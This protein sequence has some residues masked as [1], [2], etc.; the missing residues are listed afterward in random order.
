MDVESW[1]TQGHQQFAKSDF[2]GAI[3]SYDQAL[4]FNRDNYEAWTYRGLALTILGYLEEAIASSDTALQIKPDYYQAWNNRGILL[5]N[6]GHYEEAI[7]SFD[8]ALKVNS[9][10]HTAWNNRGRVLASLGQHEEALN[11]F[12]QALEIKP[13]NYAAWYNKGRVLTVLGCYEEALNSFNQALEIK[14]DYY[15]AWVN[16]GNALSSLGYHEEAITNY[17]QALKYK[18]NYHEAWH[19]RG[20]AL[21]DLSR[22]E[23]A[24]ANYDEGLQQVHKNTRPE[25]W[26]VLHHGLGRIHYRRGR[27]DTQGKVY[28]EKALASYHTACETLKDFPESYLALIQDLI[29]AYLWLGDLGQANEW[30]DK[31]L[32]VF[33]DLINAQSTNRQRRHLEA[34]FSGISRIQVDVLVQNGQ[35]ATALETAERYKNRCLTHIFEQWQENILSPTYEQIRTLLSPTTALI[36]WHLSD[37]ALTTFLLTPNAQTP[38][39]LDANRLSQCSRA[40]SLKTWLTAWNTDYSDYR[41]GFK[42]RKTPDLKHPWRTKLAVRLAELQ[43]ILGLNDLTSSL[44]ES[45]I[46]HLIL[47]PHR[48]LHCLPL[49]ACLPQFICTTLPSAQAGITLQQRSTRNITETDRLLSI[50]DPKVNSEIDLEPLWYAQLDSALLCALFS[51]HTHL[52]PVTATH[53]KVTNALGDGTHTLFHFSG[54]GGYD[55]QSPKDSALQLV[56]CPL[57]AQDLCELPLVSY[58]LLSL[59]A[60]ETALTGRQTLNEEYV[61]LASAVL[62]AG[63][64]TILSTL[65]N[66]TDVSTAYLVV[67]FYQL[68]LEGKPPAQALN[69]AQSWLRS[70]TYAGL[71]SWLQDLQGLLSPSSGAAEYVDRHCIAD[72]ERKIEVTEPPYQ[73]E[74]YWAAFTLTGHSGL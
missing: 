34:Q 12:N 41:A 29:K 11:S 28:I 71:H 33:R 44:L 58:K 56:D 20:L 38:D 4:E 69:L 62:Q 17:D 46:T 60:C 22:Y 68:C 2:I 57:T 15:E 10:D 14:P 43:G 30:R 35:L 36:Y 25:G 70:V 67:K 13:D 66:V 3:I 19:N 27:F 39:L 50:A 55:P 59:S 54:H 49:A 23:E 16:R 63:A 42:E 32:A 45:G 72:L 6:L 8:Q 64:T 7:A 73:N 53:T 18:P 37:D 65:W 9:D 47:I 1:L 5:D 31:G 51:Q 26:G 74:Y 52:N 61:G 40:Q 48:D 21:D 24:I